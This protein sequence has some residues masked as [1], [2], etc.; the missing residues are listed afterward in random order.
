MPRSKTK[1]KKKQSKV[2][3]HAQHL[4]R[5]LSLQVWCTYL[6]SPVS[7]CSHSLLAAASELARRP[8]IIAVRI[9]TGT[10]QSKGFRER[11]EDP[12]NEMREPKTI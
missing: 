4:N 7:E 6:L 2:R 10:C 3:M 12:S 5:D 9:H 11:K 1:I 8:N